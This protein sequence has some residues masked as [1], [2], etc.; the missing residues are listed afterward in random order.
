[1]S[2]YP[3]NL[4]A[5]EVRTMWSTACRVPLVRGISVDERSLFVS[6]AG[7]DGPVIL[8][9]DRATWQI[10]STVTFGEPKLRPS[11]ASAGISCIVPAL[12]AR[13]RT[14]G[15]HRIVQMSMGTELSIEMRCEPASF[16]VDAKVQDP[17]RGRLS[18]LPDRRRPSRWFPDHPGAPPAH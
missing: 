2:A 3:A 1:V 13:W 9:I 18:A 4:T 11:E 6:V 5:D 15:F 14:G 12:W 17:G 10:V 7:A 8:E 16:Q